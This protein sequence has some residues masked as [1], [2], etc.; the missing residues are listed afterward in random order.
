MFR[1]SRRL[2][3]VVFL[4]LAAPAPVFAQA[5]ISG[6][7]KDASGGVLPGVTVEAQSPALIEK[8]RSVIT[9]T[10]GQFKIVD[11]RPG[12]YSVTFGLGGFNTFKRDGIVLTGS[13]NATINAELKVGALQETITVTAESPVVDVQNITQQRVLGQDVI[14]SIPSSRTHFA[15]GALIPSVQTNNGTDVGGSNAINHTFLTAHG[16]RTTQVWDATVARESDQK[17]IAFFRCTQLII[18]PK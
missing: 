7:V 14:D 12:T 1:V 11:L 6:V 9:D 13:F 16:G 3:T 10:N 18:Y 5:S 8:M 15:V 17:H 4:L 2:R